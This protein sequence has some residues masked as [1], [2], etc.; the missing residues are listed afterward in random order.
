LIP[1]L[2]LFGISSP[3]LYRTTMWQVGYDN[4]FNSNPAVVI[5]AIANFQP[6]PNI[7]LVWSQTLTNFNV[8]IS[9]ISL[10]TLM[11]KL[12]GMIMHLYYPVMGTF[13]SVTMTALYATSVYGQAGPDYLDPRHPSP[14]AWYIAKSCDYAITQNAIGGCKVVKGTFAATVYMLFIYV[15]NLCLSVWAMWPNKELDKVEDEDDEP[16]K[17]PK[18]DKGWEMQP[19]T[20]RSPLRVPYTPRTQAFQTLDRKLP[21]QS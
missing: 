17:S 3:D 5:Y 1:L 2:V 16:K 11:V 14:A 7:P 20:P 10:F 13:L 9:V 15:A 12:I 19:Q 4:G 21:L 6:P 8:A 18:S